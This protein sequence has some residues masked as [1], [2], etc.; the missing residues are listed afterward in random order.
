[1]MRDVALL[2]GRMVATIFVVTFLD[3]NDAETI[4]DVNAGGIERM[5]LQAMTQYKRPMLS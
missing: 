4:S 2:M 3:G 1:M 5:T